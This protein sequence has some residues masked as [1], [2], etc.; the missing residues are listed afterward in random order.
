MDIQSKPDK[1]L[2]DVEKSGLQT[3]YFRY[4]MAF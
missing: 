2:S 1:F 3:S 4:K